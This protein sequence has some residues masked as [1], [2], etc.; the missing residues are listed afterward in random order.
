MNFTPF[1]MKKRRGKIIPD[2][3]N[4]EKETEQG[5]GLK[6]FI[7]IFVISFLL[8]LVVKSFLFDAYR[9]PT[10]SMENTLMIGDNI[11]ANKAAYSLSTPQTVPLTAIEMTSYPLIKISRPERN[12]VVVF[13]FPGYP[14]EFQPVQ[15]EN[16]VK[17]I[18]GLPGDTVQIIN[19]VVY[20]NGKKIP[21]PAT[22]RFVRGYVK[23]S[24]E[25]ESNIFPEGKDWNSDNY[26]PI[27]VPYKNE[28]IHLSP[29]NINRWMALIDREFE[30][31]AVRV[32]GTVITVNDHPIREYR[33]K[34]NYYFVLGDNRDN[35]VDSRYWGFVPDDYIIGKAWLIYWSYD[36][37]SNMSSVLNFWKSIKFNR[38]FTL[39]K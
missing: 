26:G 20:V 30:R 1:H 4:E 14:N 17:R 6:Y 29:K 18:I 34:K 27:I 3:K 38:I 5:S 24:A 31:K 9:I 33:L 2:I 19:K 21:A 13:K 36:S 25:K 7:K 32:E 37:Y 39:V 16:Y 22:A 12:D 15:R 10:G 8:A 35:S 23:P 28:I 11:I